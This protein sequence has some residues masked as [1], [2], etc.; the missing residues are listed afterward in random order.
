MAEARRRSAFTYLELM[1][2]MGAT[3]IVAVL[4]HTAYRTYRVRAQVAEG[5]R[6][7]ADLIPPVTEHFRR[8]G[9]VPAEVSTP[10]PAP[11]AAVPG[12]AV[13][14]SIDVIDG[15][16][17]VVYGGHADA[18]IAGRRLSL[19]PYETADAHVVWLCGNRAPGPG[20]MP[21]GFSGGGRQAA[22]IATAIAPRYLP[23]D[24]R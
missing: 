19:T 20:L 2:V 17:D 14:E 18:V 12:N 9:E 1:A 21:L 24:C 8:Y 22:P 7:A 10:L 3:I 11:G 15:R 4:A 16:I 6:F 23:R 5:I 13:V